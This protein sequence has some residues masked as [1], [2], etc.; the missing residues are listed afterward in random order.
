M[1]KLVAVYFKIQPKTRVHTI[2]T[3]WLSYKKNH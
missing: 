2:I 1:L 3:Y